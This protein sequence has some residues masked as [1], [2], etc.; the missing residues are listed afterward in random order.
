MPSVL[1][2][3]FAHRSLNE[4]LVRDQQFSVVSACDVYFNDEKT[5]KIK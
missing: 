4:S 2:S 1:I 5:L 3:A